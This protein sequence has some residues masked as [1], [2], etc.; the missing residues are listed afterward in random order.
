M[1]DGPS[2]YTVGPPDVRCYPPEVDTN[3]ILEN[4]TFGHVTS[5]HVVGKYDLETLLQTSKP[6]RI[7]CYTFSYREDFLSIH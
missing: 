1:V 7:S 2:K 5:I 6:L 3:K 4:K